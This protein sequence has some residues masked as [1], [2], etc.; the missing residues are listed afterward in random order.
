MNLTAEIL[1]EALAACTG[2]PADGPAEIAALVRE[3]QPAFAATLFSAWQAEGAP[4]NPALRYE[5][6]ATAARVEYYRSVA[7]RLMSAVGSGLSTIKGLE[8]AALYPDGF[9]RYM[10]DLDFIAPAQSDLW[11]AVSLLMQDGWDLDTATFS[12]LDGDLHVVVSFRRQPDDLYELPYGIEIATYYT[13]GDQGGI[14]PIVRL[15]EQWRVPAIK[16][17][18]MLLHERYEQPFR[19]RDLVDASLL[20]DSLRGPEADTLHAAIVALGLTVE[21]SELVR[22][23]AGTGLA[24]LA[25][26]PGG[27]W[28]G[29]RERARR[30]ARGASFFARPVAGTGR[31]LQRRVLM[32]KTGRAE[33]VAWAGVQRRLPVTT[34]VRAGLL[35]YGLPLD[36]PKP[37]VSA[38]VLCSRGPMTWADTPVGR[39]LLTIGDE[40]SEAAVEEL[41]APA[42]TTRGGTG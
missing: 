4:L 36:G 27:R 19:A 20:H 42:L 18:L 12:H 2:G 31:H 11:R 8:V 23:V 24:P 13:L 38:A 21:Y 34:A 35:A 37:D 41:S 7:S 10:N 32:G 25:E 39:F 33:S 26:L 9:V 14:P 29:A 3:T 5:V 16:N 1:V 15:P 17:M 30:L 22:L 6:A 40:V 28:P